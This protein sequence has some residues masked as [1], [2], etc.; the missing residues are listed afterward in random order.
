M[1]Y[2]IMKQTEWEKGKFSPK[3]R[4]HEEKEYVPMLLYRTKIA[5]PGPEGIGENP[6]P[7]FRDAKHD[8]DVTTNGSFTEKENRLLG[9]ECGARVLPYR[10]QDVYTRE[11]QP[12]ERD[13]IVMENEHLC[14]V[15]LPWLGGKLYSL[16]E[17][18]T[19]R[20]I[21]FTNPVFQPANLAI[22]DAWTSGGVEWN[23]GQLGHTFTTCSD[24]FFAKIR[25]ENEEPFLRMY[26]YERQKG[27]FWSI[28]F[29]L[30]DGAKVLV[31]HVRVVN[32][33][34]VEKPM[35]WWSNTACVETEEA[36]VFSDTDEVIYQDMRIEKT[37]DGH[38]KYVSY[39]FGV[40]KLPDYTEKDGSVHG[41]FDASYSMRFP[42][43]NEFFFQTPED[44]KY[45]WEAVSYKD[46]FMFLEK[47][48]QALRYR[49]MF[50]WGHG[51][52][53]RFWCDYLAEPGKGDYIELQAGLAPT[54]VHGY[55][56][57][58]ESEIV[59][60]QAFS[61][62][63]V[64]DP[65]PMYGEYASARMAAKANVGAALSDEDV[66][67]MD[68]RAR[69]LH[70]D[71]RAE[72]EIWHHGAGWG[73]LERIRRARQGR[74]IPAGFW[75]ED[76]TLT[77]EQKPWLNLL[78]NGRLGDARVSEF[79]VDERWKA[80]LEGD[81]SDAAKLHLGILH[82][83]AGREAEAEALWRQV[84]GEY[85]PMAER[86]L[87]VLCQR[88]GDEEGAVSHMKASLAAG[89]DREDAAYTREYIQML[90]TLKRY[91]AAWDAFAAAPEETQKDD[92]V[93]ILAGVAAIEVGEYAY[94]D[95][96]FRMPHA[97]VRE[98]E[99]SLTDLWFRREAA[100]EAEKRGVKVTDQLVEEM[101]HTLTPPREIDFRMS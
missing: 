82:M 27:L 12:I 73:A 94:M 101:R 20:P 1:C 87:A 59:F 52:G 71:D 18:A 50:C 15:F 41:Y 54:Q 100:R 42:R 62:A 25:P 64:A 32:D 23:I 61:C 24:V 28:D 4:L 9:S 55:R 40:A 37:E 68:A 89:G 88:K 43:A 69:R 45:P 53:G 7:R 5:L 17:K 57:A 19:G 30:P 44:V 13:A 2:D 48:T 97:A 66:E 38:D 72:V 49:K 86:N 36:R 51:R 10:M 81:D 39:G 65:A 80:L 79:M 60:T 93:S 74:G 11:R 16:T 63:H 34:K 29:H 8:R 14:A 85:K 58:P 6:L 98:G 95:E 26:E 84:G 21:L 56:I 67:A 31:A 77:A 92:R 35:Y 76:N 3:N 22:R 47:S 78:E 91:Q 46:G 70:D 99:T 83:E 96:M 90:L 75:F 33:D